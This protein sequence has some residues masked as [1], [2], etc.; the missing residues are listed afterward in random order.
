MVVKL[1]SLAYYFNIIKTIFKK[2]F[3]K[4]L[5]FLC[6]LVVFVLIEVYEISDMKS[7]LFLLK[8]TLGLIPSDFLNLLWLL[9]QI[10]L[11]VYLSYLFYF[12]EIDNSPEF[13]FM[14]TDFYRFA[15]KKYGTLQIVIIIFRLIIGLICQLYFKVAPIPWL[16]LGLNIG[17][18][19]L[20]SSLV[21][22]FFLL[23]YRKNI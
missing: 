11:T 16:V 23:F 1:N 13:I 9:Y 12:Y 17:L 10:I 21:F 3:Y 6:A 2:G 8:Y 18:Y 19:V 22:I 20:I 4:H 7:N 14:R 15:L 5:I